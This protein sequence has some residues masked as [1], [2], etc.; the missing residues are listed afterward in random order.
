MKIQKVFFSSFILVFSILQN[1]WAMDGMEPPGAL[2]LKVYNITSDIQRLP[3][4][5]HQNQFQDALVGTLGVDPVTVV[6][7]NLSFDDA[8]SLLSTNY[9]YRHTMKFWEVLMNSYG[10]TVLD[11]VTTLGGILESTLSF[12]VN[13]FLNQINTVD[14]NTPMSDRAT[15]IVGM[16]QR[17]S[18]L[19]PIFRSHLFPGISEAELMVIYITMGKGTFSDVHGSLRRTLLEVITTAKTNNPMHEEERAFAILSLIKGAL[20]GKEPGG[21]DLF[22]D[23]LPAERLRYVEDIVDRKNSDGTRGLG[24][25]DARSILILAASRGIGLFEEMSPEARSS[26]LEGKQD[27]KD[28]QA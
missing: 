17:D 20:Y 22:P 9:T 26:Y 11:D 7:G 2:S 24:A 18:F 14:M 15:S 1:T 16:I 6:I 10:L 25:D 13:S 5:D 27:L 12:I 21:Y 4:E 19:W 23:F 8:V 3:E 28:E